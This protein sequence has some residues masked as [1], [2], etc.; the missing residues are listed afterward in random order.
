MPKK[1]LLFILIVCMGFAQ[2]LRAEEPYKVEISP[3][4]PEIEF[5]MGLSEQDQ[6]L[7]LAC[8]EASFFTSMFKMDNEAISLELFQI[9]IK[10]MRK[11]YNPTTDEKMIEYILL[12]LKQRHNNCFA[13]SKYWKDFY[14]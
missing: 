14:D 10:F 9:G 11:R 8:F 13:W 4:P 2:P 3:K 6:K 1:T 5:S 12:Y 7:A